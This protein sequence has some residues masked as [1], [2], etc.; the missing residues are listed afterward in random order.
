[1][2]SFVVSVLAIVRLVAAQSSIVTGAAPGFAFGVTGGGTAPTTFIGN[3]AD[4][5]AALTSKGPMVRSS[6]LPRPCH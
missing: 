6:L 4:L 1:M 5:K 3:I 2:K